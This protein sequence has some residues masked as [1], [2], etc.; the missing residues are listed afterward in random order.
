MAFIRAKKK[1]NKVYY[2]IVE[3]YRNEEG[4]SRSTAADILER[5]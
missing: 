5:S 2:Y 4:R 1:K 3:S